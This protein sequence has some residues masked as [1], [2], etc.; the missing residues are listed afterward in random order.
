M[1]SSSTI[2]S[3][4]QVFENA[5]LLAMLENRRQGLFTLWG[6][7]MRGQTIPQHPAAHGGAPRALL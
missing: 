4:R 6:G 3:T 1:I 5:S 7:A 2:A